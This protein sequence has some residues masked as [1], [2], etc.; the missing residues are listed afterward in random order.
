[1]GAGEALGTIGAILAIT[2]VGFGLL[3]IALG[4]SWLFAR[5]P[6]RPTL[7]PIYGDFV[8]LPEGAKA[9]GGEEGFAR[10]RAGTEPTARQNAQCHIAHDSGGTIS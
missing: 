2:G 9:A 5:W 6:E 10:G 4:L 7:E 1:M 3:A 8:N